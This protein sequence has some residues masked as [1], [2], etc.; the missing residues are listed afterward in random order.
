MASETT[1]I[2]CVIHTKIRRL[3]M[4]KAG[5]VL[6]AS[7]LLLTSLPSFAQQAYSNPKDAYYKIVPIIKVW[8]HPLG[9]MVQFWTSKSKI[10]EIYIPLTWFNKGIESKADIVYTL[11]PEYPYL[12]IYWVDG[13][14]DHL[15]L[16]A[17]DSY[18]SLTW[19][20]LSQ[21]E[22]LTSQFNVQDVPREF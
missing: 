9:Y 6:A 13:K 1:I 8:M 14:F 18:N 12:T 3:P 15:T 5:F 17:V 11:G 10:S 19:G 20:V 16:Y 22:D 7:L 4:K 2:G 21:T